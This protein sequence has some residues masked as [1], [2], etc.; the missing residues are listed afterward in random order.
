MLWQQ[1]GNPVFPFD[2]T[3]FRSPEAPI[4]AIADPR[5]MPQNLWDAAAY[6]FYWV[7]GNHRSSEDPFRDQRFAIALVLFLANA[8]AS[9]FS[10]IRVLRP[11][12]R[13]FLG[14]FA[15]A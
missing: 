1:F 5:F 13:P 12:D 4:E 8:A 2:N 15:L 6:P 7:T 14:F 11:P 10:K 9:L 3:I